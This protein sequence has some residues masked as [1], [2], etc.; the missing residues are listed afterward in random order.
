[1]S[2][3]VVTARPAESVALTAQ[4]M[5]DHKVG[6]VVVVDR[7]RPRDRHPDR[8]DLSASPPRARMRRLPVAG[9]MTADPDA[10][11]PDVEAPAAF[12]SL[13]E[14]GYRHIPVVDGGTARS[15]RHRVDARPHARRADPAG[16]TPR[17]T[18]CR[19]ASKASSSPRR[20]SATCRG[21]EGFYHYRQY[22][23]GRPR[24]DSARS[25]T[26]GTSCSKGDCRRRSANARRS[27]PRSRPCRVIPAAVPE[28][29][30]E[31]RPCR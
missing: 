23:A 17:R 27:P 16:R 15:C 22:N 24:G 19:R 1:M 26:S 8:R 6:S 30:P 11:G 14:H 10:V 21:L 25:K 7:R 5:R 9:W 28:V 18:R 12:A 13:A 4:R 2:R 31:S 20:S 29:L 3:P